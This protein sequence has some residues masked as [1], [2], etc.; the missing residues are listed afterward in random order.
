MLYNDLKIAFRSLLRSRMYALINFAGLSIGLAASAL[1]LLWVRN[2]LSFDQYHR[3]ADRIYRVTNTL[4]KQDPPW[5]W[6]SSP[7]VLAPAVSAG[8]PAVEKT[9][10]LASYYSSQPFKANGKLIDD[11]DI[12]E[13]DSNW[14]SMFD[15]Q[16]LEG[17]ARAL[18]SRDAIV[19]TKTAARKCFGE[20]LAVGKTLSSGEEIFMVRAVVADHPANSGFKFDMMVPTSRTENDPKSS[21]SRQNWGNFNCQT[22]LLLKEETNALA[23]AK[24]VNTILQTNKKDSS[25]VASLI[26][27]KDIHFDNSFQS[28]SMEKGN[29]TTV[30]TM[31]LV[32]LLILV[33]ACINFVN[34]TTALISRRAKEVGLKK[35]IGAGR[36]RLFVQFL[37]ESGMQVVFGLTGALLLILLVL[38]TF[39]EFTGR[40]FTADLYSGTFWAVLLVSALVAFG[41][42]AIYPSA[43]L[44]ALKPLS[45]VQGTGRASRFN[46]LFR[47]GL[48]VAQFSISITLVIGTLCIER[49]LNYIRTK[50]P[51]YNREHVFTFNIPFESR[52]GKPDYLKDLQQ[53]FEALAAIRQVATQNGSVVQNGH[54]H[55]GSLKWPG[56]P[57]DFNPSVNTLSMSDEVPQVM[58]M[59][60]AEGRWLDDDRKAD[61]ANVVLN[62][63]AVKAFGFHAPVAGRAFEFQGRKG[64]IVGVVK[65]FHFKSFRDQITPMVIDNDRW[66]QTEFVIKT[67]GRQAPEALAGVEKIWKSEFPDAPFKYRFLDEQYDKMYQAENKAFRMFNTFSVIAVLVSCLGL[68]GLATFTI[69]ARTRE[70]GI[71][72]VLGASVLGVAGLL[73][74]DFVKL[75]L[76]AFVIAAP[77]AFYLAE[78][79]LQDFAYRVE[80]PWWVFAL[81]GV[82]A[83]AVAVVTVGLQSIRAA[84]INP[85]ATLKDE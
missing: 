5:I 52:N 55:S 63:A 58:G 50:D 83:V 44:S 26:P 75:V 24:Q 10:R 36:S 69:H 74:R 79:W 19:L 35:L 85:A 57:D 70:I 40:N 45:L 12:A 47:K 9:A 4:T 61:T 2:E 54:M 53:R 17:N 30:R 39:N 71:R 43:V 41:L 81:A 28:D 34:L 31:G 72:K 11:N 22:F 56:K 18:E 1:I 37:I 32:G 64:R 7:Y 25:V 73:S 23:V 21:K 13:V 65:D 33:V 3:H 46:A 15:Y 84:L 62:E 59:R 49:Q 16:F 27:L 80:V 76:I 77:S 48:V 78:K 82:M 6:S 8:L 68:F 38:P 42:S 14:F 67:T 66:G 51:G 60:L 20:T 29:M